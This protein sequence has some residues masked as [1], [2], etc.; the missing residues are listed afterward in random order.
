MSELPRPLSYAA[1]LALEAETGVRHEYLDGEAWA[2]AGGTVRHAKLKTNLTAD[3]SVALG[4]GPCQ[5]YDSDLKLRMLETGLATYADLAVICGPVARHPDDR[6]A[7]T[8]P[9][10]VF[11]VLSPSTEGGTAEGS[12][13]TSGQ[14]A[15][16]RHYVLR[17]RASRWWRCSREAITGAWCCGASARGSRRAAGDRRGARRGPAVSAAA[18]LSTS[19]S[20][21]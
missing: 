1:Y 4:D 20:G 3:L 18:G 5:A 11:E 15:S 10:V 19:A 12:S 21:A 14:A 13:G 2:M 7:A 8:N 6:H 16:L 17:R 9:T